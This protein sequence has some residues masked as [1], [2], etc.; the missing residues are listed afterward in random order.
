ML[1]W[2][3]PKF[4]MLFS[5]PQASS[6]SNFTRLFN[7]M[8]CHEMSK[9][10]YF[11]K[12][13]YTILKGPIKVRI[14]DTFECLDQNSPNSCH[15]WKYKSVFFQILHQSSVSWDITPLHF[16]SWNFIYFLLYFLFHLSSQKF[17]GILHFDGLRLYKS[18]KVLAK[19]V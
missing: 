1:R 19:K 11:A 16:F 18:N 4:L 9:V 8:K 6:S 12:E 5:K 7:V 10:I 14:L 17:S 3:F 15:F 2:K 13:I